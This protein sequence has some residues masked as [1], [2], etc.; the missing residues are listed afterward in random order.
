MHCAVVFLGVKDHKHYNYCP[1]EP[2]PSCPRR[3]RRF[4]PFVVRIMAA[5]GMK[6]SQQQPWQK[7]V[8]SFSVFALLVTVANFSL[9]ILASSRHDGGVAVIATGDC[10]TVRTNNTILH[11][12]TMRSVQFCS[13]A[14]T[15]RCSASWDQRAS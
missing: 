11:F 1:P 13:L 8:S 9:A 5:I 6:F 15:I 10:A 7:A 4:H 12:L 3:R 2:D 14:V